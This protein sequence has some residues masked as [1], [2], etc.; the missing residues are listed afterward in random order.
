MAAEETQN[1]GDHRKLEQYEHNDTGLKL[2]EE[3]TTI[4]PPGTYASADPVSINLQQH[5][6]QEHPYSH[7]D[8]ERTAEILDE[9]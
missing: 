8:K 1:T 6:H 4:L 9:P 5:H 7:L 3:E 2:F